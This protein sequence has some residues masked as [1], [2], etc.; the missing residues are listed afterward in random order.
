MFDAAATPA[1]LASN[2]TVWMSRAADDSGNLE[3]PTK[4]AAA[5]VAPS[6]GPNPPVKLMLTG[7]E[8]RLHDEL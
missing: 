8:Q 6:M 5:V 1:L 4:L 2:A 3:R 7:K